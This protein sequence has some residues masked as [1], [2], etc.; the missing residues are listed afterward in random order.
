MPFDRSGTGRHLH[1][2][3]DHQTGRHNIEQR[4]FYT[5]VANT[6]RD[7]ETILVFGVGPDASRAMDQLLGELHEQHS[8]IARRV[9]RTIVVDG[10][11]PC[12]G[13]LLS[14]AQE[15]YAEQAHAAPHLLQMFF[16]P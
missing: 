13:K 6:L 15:L 7:A 8:D 2:V 12:E 10:Q 1:L 3:E 16:T 14:K 4:N 9:T 5:A 11:Q